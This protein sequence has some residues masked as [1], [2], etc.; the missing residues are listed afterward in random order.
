[1]K[2]IGLK[3]LRAALGIAAIVFM[4]A[5]LAASTLGEI[6]NVNLSAALAGAALASLLAAMATY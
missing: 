2:K 4:L 5:A 3:I 6:P 1:M